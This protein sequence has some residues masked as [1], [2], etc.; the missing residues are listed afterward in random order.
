MAGLAIPR[1][2]NPPAR[3]SQDKLQL[4][5]GSVFSLVTAV[6]AEARLMLGSP[7]GEW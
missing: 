3:W 7:D 4:S 6:S 2:D 5:N 1:F